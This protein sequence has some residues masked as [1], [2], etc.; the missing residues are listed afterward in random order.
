MAGK[1]VAKT[2]VPYQ[3]GFLYYCVN[4]NGKV[5]VGE[6]KMARRTKKAKKK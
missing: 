1:I 4:S 6:A 2:E 5:A 3:K